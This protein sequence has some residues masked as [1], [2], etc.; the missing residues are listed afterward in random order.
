VEFDW[1]EGNRDKSL[2]RLN[3]SDAE[4]EEAILDPFT[5]F[6]GRREPDG[7]VRFTIL[8]RSQTSGKYLR[9]VDTVRRRGAQEV[10]RPI[11][12]VEMTHTERARCRR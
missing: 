9:I 1:D 5:V 4:I 7:E 8:G 2:V 11:S 6:I 10:I 3:V 12:A